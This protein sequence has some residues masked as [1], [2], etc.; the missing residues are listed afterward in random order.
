MH[1]LLDTDP[2][3]DEVSIDNHIPTT[4]TKNS[5]VSENSVYAVHSHS[6]PSGLGGPILPPGLSVMDGAA[7]GAHHHMKHSESVMGVLKVKVFA[8]LFDRENGRLC[9]T[10][11]V[12]GWS[13]SVYLCARW[14]EF[15][16]HISLMAP[17][18][19]PSLMLINSRAALI[20]HPANLRSSPPNS[21][22]R[23]KHGMSTLPWTRSSLSLLPICFSPWAG[24]PQCPNFATR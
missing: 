11:C 9:R 4:P 23:H 21:P 17:F 7:G 22:S 2:H 10:V 15:G 18:Y 6:P 14:C 16:R 8:S 5:Q 19:H 13:A 20:F 1:P 3:F 24:R 12:I